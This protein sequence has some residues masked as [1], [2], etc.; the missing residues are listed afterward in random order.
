M[1]HRRGERYRYRGR[2]SDPGSAFVVSTGRCGSTLISAALAL[3]PDVLSI[4][5]LF[6][7]LQPHA[8]PVG[9]ITGEEFWRLLADTELGPM[10]TLIRIGA[11]PPEM[12]YPIDGGHRFNRFTGVPRISAVTLPALSTDPDLLY[13]RLAESIPDF[14]AG[15]VAGHYRGLLRLLAQWHGRSCWVE[16]SG[17]SGFFADRLVTEF[18]DARYVHLVRDLDAT[19][20]SMSRHAFF[21]LAALRLEFLRRCQADV[22]AGDEPPGAVPTDLVPLLPGRL[23]REAFETW[24]PEPTTF[25]LMAGHQEARI[26]AAL[27]PLPP[28][29]VHRVRY[30]DLT[31]DPGAEFGRLA[32][33][34]AL[35]DPADW[36]RSAAG[37]V[38]GRLSGDPARMPVLARRSTA[39]RWAGPRASSRHGRSR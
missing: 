10:N 34:L 31:L 36:A 26:R 23:T 19:A 21:R 17:A 3:H 13:S 6:A 1:S 39:R 12:R 25:R 24:A 35:A 33:F 32:E 4:S 14:P 27:R 5:E 16:R 20:R 38:R 29:R 28:E 15:P 8:F 11:E 37:L 9:A 22:L 18:P 2:L 7:C 30:E